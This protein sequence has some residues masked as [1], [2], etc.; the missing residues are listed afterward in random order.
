VL[1]ALNAITHQVVSICSEGNIDSWSVTALLFEIRKLS[2][3][4]PISLILDNARYQRC[5]LVEHTAKLMNIELV[6]L[7]AYSP[8]LN[9]IERFWKFLKKKCLYSKYYSTFNE[10]TGAIQQCVEKA[11]VENK[12]ELET[13]LTHS[14][15]SFYLANQA[16]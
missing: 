11:H 1:G 15:Q 13:L 7:P 2:N 10:F 8:N 3:G 14:F 5:Y 6:F 4:L 9:L 12:E 16:A